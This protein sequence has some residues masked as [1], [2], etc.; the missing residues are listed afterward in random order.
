MADWVEMPLD[1]H[2][3]GF[4]EARVL[5][6]AFTDAARVRVALPKTDFED[7]PAA[8]VGYRVARDRL[9]AKLEELRQSHSPDALLKQL[10]TALERRQIQEAGE[11]YAEYGHRI[12]FLSKLE[13]IQ[14]GRRL[15]DDMCYYRDPMPKTLNVYREK[16][17]LEPLPAMEAQALSPSLRVRVNTGDAPP[18]RIHSQGEGPNRATGG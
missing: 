15:I 7:Y 16:N 13:A 9:D 14:E 11:A 1:E 2:G 18:A 5:L 8:E 17:G 12:N 6:K 10:G 4:S 3:N